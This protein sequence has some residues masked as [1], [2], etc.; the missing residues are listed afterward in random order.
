MLAGQLP[1]QPGRDLERVT[2]Q[3]PTGRPTSVAPGRGRARNESDSDEADCWKPLRIKCYHPAL[4]T[5]HEEFQV[6]ASWKL[7]GVNEGRPRAAG[8]GL[9]RL[10]EIVPWCR[11]DRPCLKRPVEVLVSLTAVV[12]AL[13]EE[14]APEGPPSLILHLLSFIE[15]LHEYQIRRCARG[16]A[17]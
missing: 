2:I 1:R 15:P 7:Y 6:G 3:S 11:G 10:G 8:V 4:A 5:N 13:G 17:R 14:P 9:L 12:R 16:V